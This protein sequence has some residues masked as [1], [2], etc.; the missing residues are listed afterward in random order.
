MTDQPDKTPV[1]ITLP[2]IN[3]DYQDLTREIEREILGRYP[4]RTRRYRIG[5]LTI[6]ITIGWRKRRTYFVGEM[7]KESFTKDKP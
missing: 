6:T 4:G 5:R 3:I 1:R 7:G 2:K